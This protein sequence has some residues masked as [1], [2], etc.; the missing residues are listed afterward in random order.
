MC[1]YNPTFNKTKSYKM[2]KLTTKR[3]SE[4]YIV[5]V[6]GDLRNRYMV[7]KRLDGWHV[8]SEVTG[9]HS[10]RVSVFSTKRQALNAILAHN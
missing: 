3:Y 10:F 9:E 5:S 7:T 2:T 1:N 8:M 4:Y 6:D